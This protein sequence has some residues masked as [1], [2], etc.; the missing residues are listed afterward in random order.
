MPANDTNTEEPT[1][2]DAL[3]QLESIVETM[4]NGEV[5]LAELIDKYESG[6]NLLRFC[7]KQLD[8][9]GERIE[10]LRQNGE[11]LIPEPVTE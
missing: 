3:Q 5:P 2:E 10:V 1:F 11:Q 6:T 7:Q 4:E 8:A 9:A